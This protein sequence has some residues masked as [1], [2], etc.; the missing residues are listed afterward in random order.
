[1]VDL[2]PGAGGAGLR[3]NHDIATRLDE[4]A[5]LLDDQQASRFRVQAWRRGAET[6]RTMERPA[7]QVLESEGLRG[8]EALP[9]IGHTLARA[10]EALVRSGHLP[11]LDRL[12]GESDPV[13]LLATVPGIG[14]VLA[15]RLHEELGVE[16]LHELELA[17]H[18]GRLERLPGF[19]DQRL[20]GI[21]DA[22]AGRLGRVR[23]TPGPTAKAPPLAEVLDVD[24]EYRR[25]ARAGT[26]PRI[27]P[28]RFNPTGAAWLPVLHT[29]RGER[30]Y[31]AL[32]SNTARAH[33]LH[34]TDDWVVIYHD[35]HGPDGQCTVVT[36]RDGPL[37][38]HRVVRGREP[39]C[40]EHYRIPAWEDSNPSQ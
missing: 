6:V 22:L 5:R 9:A 36:A 27:A 28:R 35:G 4:V 31:T 23:S 18:D 10:I 16:S 1:V 39:E 40:L 8:L 2:A 32:F 12:R 14:P 17:A 34:R 20:A 24:A 25:R 37:R 3:L 26:L 29:A 15:D 19:G 13:K 21:R 7:A 11:I 38:G 33:H 30:Q